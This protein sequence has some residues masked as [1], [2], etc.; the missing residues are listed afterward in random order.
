MHNQLYKLFLVVA[1]S[2]YLLFVV[3]VQHL[4][5]SCRPGLDSLMPLLFLADLI[6]FHTIIVPV[7]REMLVHS[8]HTS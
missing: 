3:E 8:G 4:D 5:V 7:T 6:G 2:Q 1:H